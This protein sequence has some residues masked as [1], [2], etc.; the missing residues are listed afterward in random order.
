VRI[1]NQGLRGGDFA[2]EKEPGTIRI[3][4]LGASSTFGYHD[5]DEETYPYY[6]EQILN[7][8]G[9]GRRFEVI[10]FGVPH[11]MS[12]NILALFVAEGVKLKPDVVTFYE[13][14]ND[15]VVLPREAP[16]P[17]ERFRRSSATYSVLMKLSSEI[18]PPR[19]VDRELAWSEDLAV[20]RSR[21]FLAN[22]DEI[23]RAAQANGID[24]VV[25]TQQMQSERIPRARRRGVSYAEDVAGVRAAVASGEIGPHATKPLRSAWERMAAVFDSARV[26]LVHARMMDDLRAWAATRK[27]GF[28]DGVHALDQDRDQLI[29]WVHLR[30]AANAKLADAIAREILARLDRGPSTHEAKGSSPRG[31]SPESRS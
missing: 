3:L 19:P 28:V 16:G 1:N 18:W 26:L 9:G 23:H 30:A 8:D 4:T 2:V 29:N 6:L 10:N 17:W 22:L 25:V 13:G 7:R 20:Q 27:V 5:R 31:A 15:A 21:A 14:A 24:L 12:E 11:A